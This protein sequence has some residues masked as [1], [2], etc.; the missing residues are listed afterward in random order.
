MRKRSYLK[1]KKHMNRRAK[2]HR[3]FY[4][5]FKQNNLRKLNKELIESAKMT[6]KDL[7]RMFYDGRYERRIK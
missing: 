3:R 5:K 1:W 7:N 4:I 6:I 2:M